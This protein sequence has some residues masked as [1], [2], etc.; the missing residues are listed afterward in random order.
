MSV[1][2]AELAARLV[3]EV[4][5]G[6]H[7]DRAQFLVGKGE[8]SEHVRDEVACDLADRIAVEDVEDEFEEDSEDFERWRWI[9]W[10]GSPE[11]QQMADALTAR[12]AVL[13]SE[14]E[15]PALTAEQ[16]ARLV[17]ATATVP[18]TL[19]HEWTQWSYHVESWCVTGDA[20]RVEIVPGEDGWIEHLHTQVTNLAGDTRWES[21][22]STRMDELRPA[23]ARWS[24]EWLDR[25]DGRSRE[26]LDQWS[27]EDV[28]TY[29]GCTPATVRAYRSRGEMPTPD[30]QVGRT[31]WWHAGVI[32]AWRPRP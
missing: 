32:K 11:Q 27:I 28:A 22:S 20:Y 9:E 10:H 19:T 4:E 16:Y 31:P 29:L 24:G 14:D 30:G 21:D 25:W 17:Q 23:D 6:K 18:T 2:S 13:A 8:E 26:H 7:D 1:D 5:A 3:A 15:E 12:A